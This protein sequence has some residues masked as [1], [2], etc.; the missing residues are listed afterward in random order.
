MQKP[1]PVKPATVEAAGTIEAIAPGRIQIKTITGEPW[2]L[3][4]SRETTIRVTGTAKKDVLRRGS[5]IRFTAEVDKQRSQVQGEVAKLTLFTP[6]RER[7]LGVFPEQGGLDMEALATPFGLEPPK[8]DRGGKRRS[9]RNQDAGPAIE[10]FEI[11]GQIGGV[12]KEGKLTVF[13]PPR[14]RYVR[15]P[16]EVTLAEDP[17]IEL[18]L[19]GPKALMLAKKGDQV[20]ARGRQVGPA[21]SQVMEL[22]I[23]LAEPWTMVRPKKVPR[24]KSTRSHRTKTEEGKEAVEAEKGEEPKERVEAEKGEEAEEPVEDEKPEEAVEAKEEVQEADQADA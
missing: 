3:V 12:N 23:Q 7:G 1:A 8:A 21:A 14:N 13:V 18:D 4:A 9:A 22:T 6:S 17:E 11:A 15:P 16:L 19:A 5:F 20:E 24:R 2:L 10:R